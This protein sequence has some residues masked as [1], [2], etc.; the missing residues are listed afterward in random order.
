M[1]DCTELQELIPLYIDNAIS[2]PEGKAAFEEH[3]AGC[4]GCKA[5]VASMR[6]MLA[7]LEALPDLPLPKGFHAQLMGSIRGL[8]AQS[9]AP[10]IIAEHHTLTPPAAK[11]KTFSFADIRWKT[12]TSA[13]AGVLLTI[14]CMGALTATLR[15]LSLPA[16]DSNE[17]PAAPLTLAHGEG[18]LDTAGSDIIFYAEP[19]AALQTQADA[20]LE[21]AT[22]AL[23]PV[24][25]GTPVAADMSVK[26]YSLT[27]TPEDF[28]EAIS[29]IKDFAGVILHSDMKTHK[30][31]LPHETYRAGFFEK[32]VPADQY[33]A[34]IDAFRAL[35]KVESEY[36]QQ[37]AVTYGLADLRARLNAKQTEYDRLMALLAQSDTIEILLAVDAQLQTVIA[38][39]DRYRGNIAD[40]ESQ[41]AGPIITLHLIE[42]PPIQI[43]ITEPESFA[44]KVANAFIHTLNNTTATL[45]GAIVLG[46]GL[47]LPFLLIATVGFVGYIVIKRVRR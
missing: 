41:L 47:L 29:L 12:Y 13:A 45:E 10:T 35:G 38:E 5:A 15:G 3:L 46:S 34:A 42:E 33:E 8:P 27:I 6:A 26:H 24:T 37:S 32:S 31:E 1:A 28:D 17:S 7:E 22:A 9:E 44:A 18:E 25:F 14:V 4:A 16:Q 20:R 43:I 21:R 2:S 30:S 40:Y 39:M 23:V 11:R 19:G 36:H